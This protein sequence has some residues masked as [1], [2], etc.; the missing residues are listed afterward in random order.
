[1][2]ENTLKEIGRVCSNNSI[3]VA[4]KDGIYRLFCPF[5]AI[6]VKEVAIYSIGQEITVIEVKMDFSYKL[7][8][9]IQGKAYFH[10]YFK[11]ISKPTAIQTPFN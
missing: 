2:N 11:I 6:C 5:K 8:Y 7:V 10:H 1:M 9:I 4:S 3:L